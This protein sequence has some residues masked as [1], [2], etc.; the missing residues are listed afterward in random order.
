MGRRYAT[1][2]ALAQTKALGISWAPTDTHSSMSLEVNNP[3]R[4]AETRCRLCNHATIFITK[5]RG[6]T[7]DPEG[8]QK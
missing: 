8:W 4:N 3:A 6:T 2:C 5:A 1:S 7:A